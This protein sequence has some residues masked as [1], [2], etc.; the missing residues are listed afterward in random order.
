[1]SRRMGRRPWMRGRWRR[2]RDEDEARGSASSGTSSVYLRGPATA[3]SSMT[4]D[5]A[6]WA[7]VSYLHVITSYNIFKIS[8]S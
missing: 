4:S 7:K 6:R 3:S 2:M 5:S 8:I 1:M